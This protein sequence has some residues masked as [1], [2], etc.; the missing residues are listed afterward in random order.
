MQKNACLVAGDHMKVAPCCWPA[1]VVRLQ[2]AWFQLGG[3]AVFAFCLACQ[4]P[5]GDQQGSRH[6]CFCA[7]GGRKQKGLVLTEQG[8]RC[9]EKIAHKLWHHC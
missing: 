4:V 9:V 6:H 8:S 5:L 3:N 2:A 1:S 7:P